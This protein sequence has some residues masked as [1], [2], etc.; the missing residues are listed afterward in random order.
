V[1]K[2]N[3][4][5]YSTI[6]FIRDTERFIFNYWVKTT[7]SGVITS[8]GIKNNKKYLKQFEEVKDHYS[9]PPRE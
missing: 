7:F 2:T 8:T 6:F 4:K 5:K 1:I 3:N 9:L